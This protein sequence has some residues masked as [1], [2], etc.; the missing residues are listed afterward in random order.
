MNIVLIL[1]W[2]LV[3]VALFAAYYVLQLNIKKAD[4]SLLVVT[5]NPDQTCSG[6]SSQNL[7]TITGNTCCQIGGISTPFRPVTINGISVLVGPKPIYYQST[8]QGFCD[9]G[10]QGGIELA[11]I[12]DQGTDDYITCI[13]TT[14]PKNCTG[15]AM[16]VAKYGSQLY[17]VQQA[18]W[19]SCTVTT[20]C[21]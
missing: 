8:C 16:P 9:V 7:Y 3:F 14:I 2:I 17:Y 18:T 4:E 19:E 6:I 13:N 5:I 21:S 20:V 1:I 11:C 12:N 10:V 15:L